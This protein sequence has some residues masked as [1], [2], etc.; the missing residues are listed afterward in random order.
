VTA[1]EDVAYRLADELRFIHGGFNRV[2][3]LWKDF[4]PCS[5]RASGF[6]I[7]PPPELPGINPEYA[8]SVFLSKPLSNGFVNDSDHCSFN[9]VFEMTV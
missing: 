1:N 8:A 6:R 9:L 3:F 2:P 7:R 5:S 4:I